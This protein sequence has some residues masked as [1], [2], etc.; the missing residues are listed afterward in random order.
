MPLLGDLQ[1]IPSKI[2]IATEVKGKLFKS[3]FY[4]LFSTRKLVNVRSLDTSSLD[5]PKG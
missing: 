5:R 4:G 3:A 1:R 2:L